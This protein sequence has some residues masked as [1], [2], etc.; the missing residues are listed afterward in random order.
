MQRV[1]GVDPHFSDADVLGRLSAGT[2]EVTT[3]RPVIRFD[4]KYPLD[5][6]HF[7]TA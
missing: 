2:L 7:L 3:F 6:Q 5:A 1:E 4:S